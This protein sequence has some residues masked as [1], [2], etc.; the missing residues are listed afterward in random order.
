MIGFW[1]T[2][3]DKTGKPQSIVGIYENEGKYYGRIV[4]TI[5]DNGNIQDTLDSPNK[6]A[7]GVVGNPYYAGLDIIWNLKK[8]GAEYRD[9]N[10]IDPEAGK[11][12]GASLW[13]QGAN[14]IVRGEILIFGRNQQWL[15][16][17][18]TVFP[19]RFA[20]PDLASLTPKIPQV[21]DDD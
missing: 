5:D 6:R 10:I 13:R 7:P 14:L 4:V 19:S 3:D 12:Y 21:K 1:K 11:V 8:K 15:P 16:A 18:E 20:K 9:G 17:A 2:I